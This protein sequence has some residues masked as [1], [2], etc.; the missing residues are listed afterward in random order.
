MFD[1]SQVIEGDLGDVGVAVSPDVVRLKRE[2]GTGLLGVE[3]AFP[4]FDLLSELVSKRF[5]FP[6]DGP[7]PRLD[8]LAEIDAIAVSFPFGHDGSLTARSNRNGLLVGAQF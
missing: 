1:S 4:A 7:V 8:L 2:A 5:L 6:D 3:F